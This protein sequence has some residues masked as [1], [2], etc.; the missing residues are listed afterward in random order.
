MLASALGVKELPTFPGWARCVI[1][2]WAD[3]QSLWANEP[4]NTHIFCVFH[5]EELAVSLDL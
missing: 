1:M 2:R 3:S 5:K 4:Q